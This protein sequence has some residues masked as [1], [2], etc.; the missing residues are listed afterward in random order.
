MNELRT[1][2]LV[3]RA[4]RP[5]GQALVEGVIALAL[6]IAGTVGA[7]LLMTN[8]GLSLFFKEKL[9]FCGNQAAQ[10]AFSMRG[11]PNVQAET[12]T[13]VRELLPKLGVR[14]DDLSVTVDSNV[15]VAGRQ[16]VS[17][18]IGN[19]CSLLGGGSI[20]P[21]KVTLSDT[22]T[23]T[24]SS[25]GTGSSD[26]QGYLAVGRWGTADQTP[27]LLP[28]SGLLPSDPGALAQSKPLFQ[29]RIPQG[30]PL[31]SGGGA[32]GDAAKLS[33]VSP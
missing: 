18:T 25:S 13:F 33:P 11:N 28:I 16:A 12:T 2:A 32:F 27:L 9:A 5:N 6:I 1:A 30:G 21:T 8:V 20:I 19:A 23:A 4:R 22:S 17:V 24:S 31:Q 3:L 29:L 14:P 10:V 26:A 15:T 7:V